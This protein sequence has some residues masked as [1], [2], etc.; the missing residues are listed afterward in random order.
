MLG[1]RHP[2]FNKFDTEIRI[3][4]KMSQLPPSDSIVIYNNKSSKTEDAA[5]KPKRG[6][7]EVSEEKDP[8]NTGPPLESAQMKKRGRPSREAV[9]LRKLMET[10]DC[11][12]NIAEKLIKSSNTHNRKRKAQSKSHQ[13]DMSAAKNI[14]KRKIT[15]N[16]SGSE[17][18]SKMDSSIF[19]SPE[20]QENNAYPLQKIPD[21][22]NISEQEIALNMYFLRMRNF[23]TISIPSPQSRMHDSISEAL[24]SPEY[25]FKEDSVNDLSDIQ[26]NDFPVVITPRSIRC[27]NMNEIPNLTVIE[28]L[29][30]FDF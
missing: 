20:L 13:Q 6:R 19:H 12:R 5:K 25:K 24:L 28:V 2:S 10:K 15:V 14:L 29:E 1:R 26:S 18:K 22:S 23:P 4:S 27:E 30:E 21:I 9:L 16:S 3:K 7:R 8:K 17:V 11:E